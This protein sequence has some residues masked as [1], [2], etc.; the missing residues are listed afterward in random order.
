VTDVDNGDEKCFGTV[1]T[2]LCGRTKGACRHVG[3]PTLKSV[4]KL[5]KSVGKVNH[6]L[7][8][9]LSHHYIDVCENNYLSEMWRMIRDV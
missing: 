1:T 3:I 6:T 4:L 2:S 9:K 8:V 5:K 7:G